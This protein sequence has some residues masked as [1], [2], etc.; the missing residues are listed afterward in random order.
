MALVADL[1]CLPDDLH[2]RTYEKPTNEGV[3]HRIRERVGEI[4]HWGQAS[5]LCRRIMP[6]ANR[7]ESFFAS[8]NQ[9]QNLTTHSF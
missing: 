2:H 7:G 1:Q 6:T 3:E 9:D 4:Q 5:G 8:R